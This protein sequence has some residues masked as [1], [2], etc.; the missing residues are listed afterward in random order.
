MRPSL[1]MVLIGFCCTVP[2]SAQSS[3]P[4][5]DR[6]RAALDKYRDPVVAVG[7]GYLST[8]VCMDFPA[9]SDSAHVAHPAGGMGVHLLNAGLIG[10]QV[11]SLKPQVLIYEPVGDTLKL[12]AAE[13]FVPVQVAPNQPEL[14]GRKFDGPMEGHPPIMPTGLH[15]WD[16]HVWLWK[17][18]PA[19]VFA[20][21][22]PS[23]KCPAKGYS[24]R[25][26]ASALVGHRH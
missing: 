10:P 22:N 25:G 23:L 20:S 2:L 16:L 15:H 17:P 12:V 21:T 3:T 5:L 19:G 26:A 1:A 18:N 7:D 6:V 8:V 11:D 9:V 24:V 14:F 4:Q 13:W